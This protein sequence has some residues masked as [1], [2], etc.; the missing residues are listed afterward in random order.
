[1]WNELFPVRRDTKHAKGRHGEALDSFWQ[2]QFGYGIDCLTELEAQNLC[3]QPSVA[4]IQDFLAQ[5]AVEARGRGLEVAA[6]PD[7][8]FK[9]LRKLP[10]PSFQPYLP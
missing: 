8:R 1:M 9:G 4:A 3:R 10:S 5:A 7:G 2:T 6:R